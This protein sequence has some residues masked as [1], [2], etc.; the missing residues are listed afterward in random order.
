[1]IEIQSKQSDLEPKLL[2][3]HLSFVL[4]LDL[5]DHIF[6][7]LTEIEC[8]INGNLLKAFFILKGMVLVFFSDAAIS[9]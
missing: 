6:V 5:Y 9:L 4:I 2:S 7:H 3:L 8:A 1:M